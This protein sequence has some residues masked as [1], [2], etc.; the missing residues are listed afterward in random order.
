MGGDGALGAWRALL[1]YPAGGTD[2]IRAGVATLAREAPELEA[3]LRPLSDYAD[4][5]PEGCLEE[6]FTRTFDGN[7][8]RALE[9]GWHLHGESPSRGRFL[10]R[11]RELLREHGLA[12]GVELP[13]HLTNLLCLLERA[14]GELARELAREALLP[15]LSKIAAGFEDR[16]NP[17]RGV[18][19][20]LARRLARGEA[21]DE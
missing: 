17:Y 1:E 8:E 5:H 20:A 16:S 12:E 7:A 9:A 11:M 19:V 2:R 3:E 10:V 21:G 4:T 14:D 15:A 18:I 13:D 6:L